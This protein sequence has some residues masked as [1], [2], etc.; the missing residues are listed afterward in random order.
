[1]GEI[2]KPGA[3][4]GRDLRPLLPPP[5]LP[6]PQA[7]LVLVCVKCGARFATL[8]EAFEHQR[9]CEGACFRIEPG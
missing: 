1:M 7:R 5:R 3:P 8:L 2:F 4:I 6:A 9:V